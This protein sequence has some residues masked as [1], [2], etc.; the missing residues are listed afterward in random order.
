[1]RIL[2]HDFAG[3]PYAVQLSREL[4]RRDMTVLHVYSGSNPMPQGNLRV[5]PDDPPGFQ[6]RSV[7]LQEKINKAKLLKRRKQDVEHG[8]RLAKVIRD[9]RPDVLI[10]GST[11]LDTQN[12]IWKVCSSMGVAKVFWLQDVTG[13]AI[14][15]ILGKRLP[16]VGHALGAYYE[17]MEER[18]LRQ[19]DAVVAITGDFIKVLKSCGVSPRKVRVIENW[20]PLDEVPPMPK[21]NP[22]SVRNGL[23][24]TFNFIYSGSLGMKHDPML[25]LKLAQEFQ[26]EPNV[27]VVVVTEGIG[28][29][30]LEQRK[31]E[32][33]VDNLILMDFVPFDEVPQMMG[34]SDVM[35]AVLEPNA[36]IFSV[37][38][39]VFSYLCSERPVLLS[40]PP[41]NLAA[42]VVRDVQAGLIADPGD[43]KSFLA[44]ARS[45]YRDAELREKLGMNGRRYAEKAYNISTITSSFI[46]VFESVCG[47]PLSVR[48]DKEEAVLANTVDRN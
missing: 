47:T 14:K 24:K 45:L 1:M 31:A 28:R 43:Q 15:L 39:K 8:A 35:T 12:H 16:L 34:A 10:S 9:F 21:S 48:V 29:W 4:A 36:G 20:G 22:W 30:W 41:E 42:R 11:P 44:Q 26:N 46:D 2:V 6:V 38:S 33:G 17:N 32:L 7:L 5:L 40:V 3:H 23:D 37:P 27:R 19:S 25:M 18:L 13:I